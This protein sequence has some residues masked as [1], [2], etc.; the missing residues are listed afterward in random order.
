M[1]NTA[2]LDVAKSLIGAARTP[3]FQCNHV[4]NQVL[5][6]NKD[7]KLAKEYLKYGMQIHFPVPGAVVVGVDGKHVGIFISTTQFIH[8]S[9]SRMEVVVAGMDQLKYVFREGW[10]IRIAD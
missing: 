7:G 2:N 1:A 6:G 4:V 10:E 3:T 5:T 8:S 9:S